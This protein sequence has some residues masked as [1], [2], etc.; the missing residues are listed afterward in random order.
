MSTN[1]KERRDHSVAIA[2]ITGR[3]ITQASN[4]LPLHLSSMSGLMGYL[5]E[6]V[7]LIN[8]KPGDI[9]IAND[10]H[11][12]G[13]THLPDINMAMPVFYNE[14]II[15]FICNIAHHAD[16]GG[17]A[18]GSMS[19]GMREIYQEGVRIPVVRLF[20]AGILDED[21]LSLLLLNMRLVEERRGDI[22]AQVAAC[23][24]GS[25]RLLEIV[26]RTGI[27][28]VLNGFSEIV[29][30]TEKRMRQ[31]LQKVPDGSYSFEDVMDDDGLDTKDIPIKVLINKTGDRISFDFTGSGPQVE[32]NINM[33]LNATQ[34]GVCYA[35]KALLD[36]DIPNNQ[37]VI[38]VM[39]MI[40][41]LQIV[42]FPRQLRYGR[43]VRNV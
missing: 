39:E 43:T 35:M 23:R 25:K 17:M 3:L 38:D 27:S 6:K 31:A 30:R 20:D 42:Y 15:A 26:E 7:A 24:L 13:G 11:V 19:S 34:C 37:G 40:A 28:N 32:G 2:D 36:P 4:A 18:A 21:L 1:I 22:N 29:E 16:I 5:L 9:Y 14:E 33:T 8:M 12:A 41:Q 10:P